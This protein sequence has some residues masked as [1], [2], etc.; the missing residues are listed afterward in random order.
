[1]FQTIRPFNVMY[2][3]HYLTQTSELYRDEGIHLSN[4]WLNGL[5]FGS[6]D[7]MSNVSYCDDNE[8]V[9]S[10]SIDADHDQSGVDINENDIDSD[11]EWNEMEERP[12]GN[13][14]TLLEPVDISHW[15][16]NLLTVAP[17]EGN[18][19][20]GIFHDKNS[21]FLAFPSIFL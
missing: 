14:D 7:E 20:L 11:D 4:E 16:D 8:V 21:E 17:G 19:P 12:A 18:R 9:P 10:E 6:D 1:M 3:A 13:T 5:P 2:A 15:A